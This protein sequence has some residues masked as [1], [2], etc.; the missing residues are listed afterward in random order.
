M[1]GA[2]EWDQP[3]EPLIKSIFP[4]T[5]LPVG[6]GQLFSFFKTPLE[7]NSLHYSAQFQ[8]WIFLAS[9]TSTTYATGQKVQS[10]ASF[11]VQLGNS[12][13]FF[14]FYRWRFT[15]QRAFT[16][17]YSVKPVVHTLSD[18]QRKPDVL[19]ANYALL[20][21]VVNLLG[22]PGITWPNV[23]VIIEIKLRQSNKLFRDEV[24]LEVANKVMAMFDQQ[25]NR[26][27]I[28]SFEILGYKGYFS[29]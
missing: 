4:D 7:H 16:G 19:G 10:F 17:A 9:M 22:K 26:R 11:M 1:S 23:D 24:H 27:F 28:P 29:V 8:R 13:L 21:M 6:V 14:P 2:I 3:A 12:A 18:L 25:P 5:K 20:Q 15:A